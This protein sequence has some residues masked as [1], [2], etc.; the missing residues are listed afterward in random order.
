MRPLVCAVTANKP[1][2]AAKLHNLL[3]E[4]RSKHAYIMW[5]FAK[6]PQVTST[7]ATMG[8]VQLHSTG[9]YAVLFPY[10]REPRLN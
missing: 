2:A 4:S 8:V 6:A 5:G 7:E 3:L 10:L 9:Q 1:M